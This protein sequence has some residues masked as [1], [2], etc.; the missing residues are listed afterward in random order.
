MEPK[1]DPISF[2]TLAAGLLVGQKISP[3][4]SAYLLIIV[5]STAGGLVALGRQGPERKPTG[6]PFLFIVNCIALA[7]TTIVST[8]LAS[9]V[10]IVEAPHLYAP[11][12][13]AIGMI[14]L[15]WK[16]VVPELFRLYRNWRDRGKE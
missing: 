3:V 10:D 14:G 7:C 1:Y 16:T 9:K 5:M 15:D 4:F 11:V 8:F 6:L 2:I 12:A 13:L